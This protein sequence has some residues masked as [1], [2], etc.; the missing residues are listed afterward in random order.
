MRSAEVQSSPSAAARNPVRALRY[1]VVFGGGKKIP[2]GQAFSPDWA[3]AIRGA[4]L[5]GFAPDIALTRSIRA[6][7]AGTRLTP[8]KGGEILLR[9]TGPPGLFLAG[10]VCSASLA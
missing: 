9:K 10:P 4:A 1:V 7:G 8:W 6:T 2:A 5:P 3:W